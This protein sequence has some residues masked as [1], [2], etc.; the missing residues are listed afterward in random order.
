MGQRVAYQL[1]TYKKRISAKII[2]KDIKIAESAAENLERTIVL[3]GDGLDVNILSEAN[4]SRADTVLAI[5]D[6]DKKSKEYIKGVSCP[7]C[8]NSTTKNQ[9]ERY[10]SRQKQVDLAK[11][12]NQ[13]H[14]GPKDKIQINKT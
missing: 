6:D 8:F 4:V 14:I 1:E 10:M 11:A 3:N 13:K 7:K 9:K 5:T 2:E 12:R